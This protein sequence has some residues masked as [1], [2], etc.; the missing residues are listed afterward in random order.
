MNSLTFLDKVLKNNLGTV[1]LIVIFF[2]KLKQR[3][4]KQREFGW[5]TFS[6]FFLSFFFSHP[7]H[8]AAYLISLFLQSCQQILNLE[9]QME[10]VTMKKKIANQLF[11]WLIIYII[12]Y[13]DLSQNII[14]NKFSL[15]KS[16]TSGTR[17]FDFSIT[18]QRWFLSLFSS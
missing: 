1:F 16:S 5:E 12:C 17:C 4:G 2:F 13:C 3:R 9:G 6:S 11:F 8:V 15:L 14:E 7:S 10:I 18:R